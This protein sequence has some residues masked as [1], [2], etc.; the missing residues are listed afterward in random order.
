MPEQ[1]TT[2][3]NDRIRVPQVRLIDE[4]GGQVGVMD[5]NEALRYAQ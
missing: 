2:R 1:D 4:T 3:T 5:T